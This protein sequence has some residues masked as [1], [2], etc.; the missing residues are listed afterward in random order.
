MVRMVVDAVGSLCIAVHSG[1]PPSRAEWDA[2]M[3][4]VRAV[5]VTELRILAVT[6]G[7]APGALERGLLIDHLRGTQTRIAVL[8]DSLAVRGAATALSWF[9]KGL[10]V[11]PPRSIDAALAHLSISGAEALDVR[12]RVR[13]AAAALSGPAIK[14]TTGV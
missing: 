4:A 1:E 10:R 13:K 9:T 3:A 6:D 14:A 8:S 7:G 11:F 12:A 2:F 5:P